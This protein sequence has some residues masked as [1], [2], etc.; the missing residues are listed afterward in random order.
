LTFLAE[1][2]VDLTEAHYP[3]FCKRLTDFIVAN[4]DYA[5]LAYRSTTFFQYYNLA[6]AK[7]EKKFVSG[8]GP[9]NLHDTE[10]AR[11]A[12][13]AAGAAAVADILRVYAE[14]TDDYARSDL[15]AVLMK[16]NDARAKPVV[17]GD[18]LGNKLRGSDT[19]AIRKWCIRDIKKEVDSVFRTSAKKDLRQ[20]LSGLL[21]AL[22]AEGNGRTAIF[23]ECGYPVRV[24]YRDRSE[25]PINALC[26]IECP[27]QYTNTYSCGNCGKFV[28]QITQ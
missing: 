21:I 25:G 22:E 3:A 10:L 26:K 18:L 19:E 7:N 6:D 11:E 2:K 17:L 4:R 23:C 9:C 14:I 16:I 1:G 28:Y 15:A 12:L 8:Y 5:L 13:A 20:K 24:R 27:E